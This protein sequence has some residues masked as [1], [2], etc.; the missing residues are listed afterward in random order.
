MSAYICEGDI[1][2][3][4]LVASSESQFDVKIE[5]SL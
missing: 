4:A 5:S 2:W 3:K 1:A